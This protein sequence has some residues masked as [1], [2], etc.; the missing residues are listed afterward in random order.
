MPARSTNPPP[1]R[2]PSQDSA[3]DEIKKFAKLR[4]EGIISEDEFNSKKKE[5]LGLFESEAFKSFS[6][7]LKSEFKYNAD[8][9]IIQSSQKVKSLYN[10]LL[11]DFKK[12]AS[13]NFKVKLELKSPSEFNLFPLCLLLNTALS[14]F[15]QDITPSK[16]EE[17]LEN[18][19]Q[20]KQEIKVQMEKFISK[21]EQRDIKQEADFYSLIDKEMKEAFQNLYICL[22]SLFNKCLSDIINSK[23]EDLKE[24]KKDHKLTRAD[25][26]SYN[27]PVMSFLSLS[28][29][30]FDK[31]WEKCLDKIKLI[32]KG[33][34]ESRFED[35]PIA[36]K[37]ILV[38]SSIETFL[39]NC[40]KDIDLMRKN[41]KAFLKSFKSVQNRFAD[42]N[43]TI[44]S[45][46]SEKIT[47]LS[48]LNPVSS[49]A[50]SISVSY[51][52]KVDNHK[53]L[54]EK[55]LKEILRKE[56]SKL[57]QQVSLD[58]HYS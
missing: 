52:S 11:E 37:N 58:L 22:P 49:S 32:M 27:F 40:K 47:E 14:K 18:K 45:L 16:L 23:K 2:C 1:S 12:K 19:D 46:S 39:E 51:I 28:P 42:E 8:L 31:E 50:I 35:F 20:I 43:L 26:Y 5:L 38:Q 6:D 7:S 55:A 30:D 36:I 15:E 13:A 56:F 57:T 29:A 21:I 25:K 53:S 34:I 24:K 9:S 44:D 17:L 48:K 4:D 3:A 10:R 33:G 41:L 54:E